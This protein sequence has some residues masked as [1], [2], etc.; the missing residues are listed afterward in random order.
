[1]I[2]AGDEHEL[3]NDDEDRGK[4]ALAT[5]VNGQAVMARVQFSDADK[6]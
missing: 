1:M 6:C 5:M 2:A 3:T 4:G